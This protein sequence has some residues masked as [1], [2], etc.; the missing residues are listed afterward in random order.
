MTLQKITTYGNFPHE[1][2][3]WHMWTSAGSVRVM[4]IRFVLQGVNQFESPR[5]LDMSNSL[6]CGSQHLVISRIM[7]FD[8]L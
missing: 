4:C 1:V 5:L 3:E 2:Y 7:N 6:S 8:L